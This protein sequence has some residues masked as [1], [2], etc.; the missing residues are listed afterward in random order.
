MHAANGIEDPN[1]LEL[2]LREEYA[3]AF[4]TE[5]YNEFWQQVLALSKGNSGQPHAAVGSTT[6]ADRLPSYRLFVDH[7]LDPDQPTVTRILDLTQTH[8][9]N[10][11]LL[12]DYFLETANASFLCSRLLRDVDHTRVKY[13]SLKTTLDSLQIVQIPQVNNLPVLLTRLEEFS[14]S[15]NPFVPSDSSPNRIQAVQTNCSELLKR[16]EWSRDKAKARFQLITKLKHG[17]AVFLVALTA[18]LTIIIT[19]HALA[20]LVATPCVIATSVEL[21]SSKKLARWS[22]QLDAAAKGTYILMRDLDTKS[23]LVGRLSDELEH[24]RGIVRFWLERGDDRLQASRE[25]ARQLKMNSMSFPDQLDELEEHLYL[26]FMTINRAR[27]LVL[28]E[29]LD[30]GHSTSTSVVSNSLTE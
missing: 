7:L 16:L 13:K 17:S 30:P 5:S 1:H 9:E 10:Q 2:D 25:V 19:T 29:I 12:S 18:S 28:K 23:R 8:P 21:P 14:S 22:A 4:R 3:N 11:A 15:Y 20:L 26:C 6:T 27:N 24:M